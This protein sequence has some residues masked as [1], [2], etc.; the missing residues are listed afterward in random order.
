MQEFYIRKG[1]VNPVLEM[2]LIKDGRYD[3]QKS[4]MNEALQDSDVTFSMIDEETG[5]LKIANAPASVVLA[6][7]DSC[8]EKYILQYKW[9]ERDTR[10]E[11]IYN[12][13]FDIKF[14]GDL[15]SDGVEYPSGNMKVPI[16][17]ELRIIIK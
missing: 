15:T 1:S 10:K 12:G 6:D 17:E 4:L 7:T 16:E 5:L 11:G 3:F 9:R 8:D 2:E 13:W 14:H